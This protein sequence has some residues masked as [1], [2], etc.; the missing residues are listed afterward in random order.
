MA[1]GLQCACLIAAAFAVGVARADSVTPSTASTS[2]PSSSAPT[3]AAPLTLPPLPSPVTSTKWWTNC[4]GG[5]GIWPEMR[6][7]GCNEVIK[8]GKA[9]GG[10]LAKVYYLRGNANLARGDYAKAIDDYDRALELAKDD[11]NALSERCW[12]RAVLGVEIDGALADCNEALR[13]R[14]NDSE[15]LAARG[16]TYMRLGLFRT[17]ILDYDAALKLK[18]DNAEHLYA[19]GM[20]K[21]RAGDE[22]A[23]ETDLGAARAIDSKVEAAFT[24]YDQANQ[25]GFWTGLADYWR[26]AMKWIY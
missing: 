19:R 23:G 11:A 22:E 8:S 25:T 26:A 9:T 12:A 14:P 1:Y 20:A 7:A 3:T 24:R 21:V 16:F 18:P 4:Q 17:A 15:T 6:I 13:L 2:P 5:E 10:D